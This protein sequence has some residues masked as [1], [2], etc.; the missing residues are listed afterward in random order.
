[1]QKSVNCHTYEVCTVYGGRV[2]IL[3]ESRAHAIR[4]F[5]QTYPHEKIV[6]VTFVY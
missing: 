3:A 2:A 4:K 6:G 5:N 1:M